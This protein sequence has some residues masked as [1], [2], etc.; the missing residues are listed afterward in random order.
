EGAQNGAWQ[1]LLDEEV[2]SQDHLLALLRTQPLQGRTHVE[3]VPVVPALRHHDRLHVRDTLHRRAMTIGPIE[4]EG[5][6]PVMDDEGDAFAH[7]QGLEQGFEIATMLDEA[8]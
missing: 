4:T 5:R 6:A 2:V 8:I 7:I 1:D 3:L